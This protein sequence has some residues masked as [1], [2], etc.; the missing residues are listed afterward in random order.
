M[1][2]RT[3]LFYIASEQPNH[4]EIVWISYLIYFSTEVTNRPVITYSTKGAV[5]FT[6][7]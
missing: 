2:V 5:L 6:A 3:A 1:K 4:H 7:F